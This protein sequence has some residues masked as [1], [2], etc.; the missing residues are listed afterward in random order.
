[1]NYVSPNSYIL[2]VHV[3]SDNIELTVYQ[4]L[5]VLKLFLLLQTSTH[6]RIK[7]FRQRTALSL[8]ATSVKQ[9][10]GWDCATS[11]TQWIMGHLDRITVHESIWHINN[12]IVQEH[13]CTSTRNA[14]KKVLIY[15]LLQVSTHLQICENMYQIIQNKM[16]LKSCNGWVLPVVSI[17]STEVLMKS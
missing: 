13:S 3:L 16:V 17:W 9:F 6:Y 10:S 5:R 14:T 7:L 12:L 8:F 1:M 4:L 11:T 2:E 15:I